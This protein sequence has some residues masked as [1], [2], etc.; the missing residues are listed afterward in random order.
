MP[1]D[2]Q[3]LA[4]ADA[5]HD[6][7]PQRAATLLGAISAAALAE[8]ERPR[9]AFLLNH[10]L[11]EKLG[12]WLLAQQHQAAL[13]AVAGDSAPPVLWRQAAVAATLAGGPA[14]G[15][16]AVEGLARA[17]AVGAAQA[18]ELVQLSA[19][20]FGVGGAPAA[21]A[22]ALALAA[23][24][25]LD[26]VHWQQASALDAAA[27]AACNNLAA[28]LSERPVDELR[29]AALRA[30][31][32]RAA[33]ASQWLWQRAGHW[34]HHERACYGVAVAAGAV[35]DAQRQCEAAAAGLALLDREDGAGEQRV[36]RAFLE[37]EL[38][39]GRRRLG[40]D[41]AAAA[42]RARADALAATFDDVSL[43]RWYEARV[44]RH[45]Q[46]DAGA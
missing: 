45:R 4:E 15:A 5:C 41:S 20:G 31:L 40:Q 18:R 8:D 35:G 3:H 22:G 12:A 27:A 26:A 14:A 30:A 17:A 6:D 38:A 25:A 24:Q 46:L 29:D 33:L 39:H 19:A 16:Q 7:D 13:L 2:A 10:V 37:L 42:A 44:E 32:S 23:L 28:A 36:D 43:T 21:Q 9:Y 11:G 34:V 1:T